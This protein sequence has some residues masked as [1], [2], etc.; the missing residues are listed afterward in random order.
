MGKRHLLFWVFCISMSVVSFSVFGSKTAWTQPTTHTVA[1]GDTLESICIRYY[2]NR[3]LLPKLWK[4]NPYVTNPSRLQT[5]D[6]TQERGSCQAAENDHR[7][8]ACELLTQR[9]RLTGFVKSSHIW[10]GITLVRK[11]VRNR[12]QRKGGEG[13]SRKYGSH[14]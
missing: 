7:R 13:E 14:D 3:D 11:S 6:I 12:G 9:E 8:L 10:Q 1:K 2:G 4:K 5:G